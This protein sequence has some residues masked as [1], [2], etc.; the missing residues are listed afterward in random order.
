M[1]DV[2]PQLSADIENVRQKELEAWLGHAELKGAT[3]KLAD[4]WVQ[5]H[6]FLM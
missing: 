3:M 6:K 4:D 2:H 1:G 5:G